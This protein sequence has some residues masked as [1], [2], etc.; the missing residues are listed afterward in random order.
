MA[1][2]SGSKLGPYEIVAR[3]GAGGM[4]KVSDGNSL[5]YSLAG[6]YGIARREL[7]G[8]AWMCT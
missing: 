1:L 5:A 2:A 7:I 8:A 6:S 4:G 3:L